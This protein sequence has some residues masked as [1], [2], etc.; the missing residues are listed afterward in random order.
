MAKAENKYAFYLGCTAPVRTQ[1]YELSTRRIASEL[2]MK[3]VDLDFN[4]CGFPLESLD[5]RKAMAI[6]LRNLAVAEEAGFTDIVT[7]CTGCAGQLEK[8]NYYV[9]RDPNLLRIL[10]KDISKTGYCYKGNVQVRHFVRVLY[11]DIT[12]QVIAKR[13][14]KKFNL[15]KVAPFYGCHYIRPTYVTGA[16]AELEVP[17]TLNSL[18]EV[19]GVSTLNFSGNDR[20]CG[21]FLL[22]LNQDLAFSMSQQ[23][24]NE[25]RKVAPDAIVIVCPFCGMML[26]NTIK[27]VSAG[28]EAPL[29]MPVLY[30]PQLLGL[31]LG[32]DADQLCIVDE[33]AD[34]FS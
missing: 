1:N 8:T 10:N 26:Q 24:I 31:A 6:S 33:I 28:L 12:P 19:T 13:V 22:G 32:V 20:C 16:L 21:G 17:F 15:L 9:K 14:L 7:I 2:G 34:L 18:I 3:L 11:Q 23:R 27:E 5:S 4:C 25:I 30:Y 29:I